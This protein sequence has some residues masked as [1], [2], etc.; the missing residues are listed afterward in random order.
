MTEYQRSP[1]VSNSRKLIQAENMHNKVE[2]MRRNR[3]NLTYKTSDL[4][5]NRSS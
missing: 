3:A 2:L 1:T 4:R 5:K